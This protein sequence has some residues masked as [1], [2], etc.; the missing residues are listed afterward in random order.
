MNQPGFTEYFKRYELLIEYKNLSNPSHCPAG[1]YVMPLPD[2]LYLWH[3]T[4]FIHRGYY[5]GG[6]YKFIIEIPQSYPDSA[7]KVTFITDMFHPLIDPKTRVFNLAQQFPQWRPRKDYI[8]HLLHYIKNCFKEAVLSSLHAQHCVNYESFNLF[9]TDRNS[10]VKLAG[11]CAQ[12]S[13]ALD[14]LLDSSE[15]PN[16]S[17]QFSSFNPAGNMESDNGGKGDQLYAAI[18]QEMLSKDGGNGLK[19]FIDPKGASRQPMEAEQSLAEFLSTSFNK[20]MSN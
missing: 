9:T 3:G 8:C 19:A 4:L 6:V 16:S 17:M 1:L 7:P 10:F 2:N 11:Q 15:F 12:L 13:C 5:K 20:L 14:V 18:R